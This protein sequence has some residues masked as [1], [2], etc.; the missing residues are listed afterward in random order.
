MAGLQTHDFG[1]AF[2]PNWGR[3]AALHG[4]LKE[5]NMVQATNIMLDTPTEAYVAFDAL[6]LY[7]VYDAISYT[8]YRGIG[9]KYLPVLPWTILYLPGTLKRF[10]RL[11][12]KAS[13]WF[14]RFKRATRPKLRT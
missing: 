4:P 13:V 12:A 7:V 11:A 5:G 9:Y 2:P 6:W 1:A 8:Q 3:C 14:H 10:R